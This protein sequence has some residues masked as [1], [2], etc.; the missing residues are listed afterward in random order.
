M[1]CLLIGIAISACLSVWT[2][3]DT[4]KYPPYNRDQ[5]VIYYGGLS[6]QPY[7]DD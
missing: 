3:P 1:K 4:S 2:G 5:S 7:P 6:P